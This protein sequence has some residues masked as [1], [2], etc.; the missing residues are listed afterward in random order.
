MSD[1][2]STLDDADDPGGADSE[3]IVQSAAITEIEFLVR[4]AHRVAAL[5][6]LVER[7][8]SR[9]DL[10]ALTAASP[11]TIARML[12]E[13][14]QRHWIE[15]DGH[16]YRATQLGVFVAS[17]L[18]E[19]L[20]RIET[21]QQLRDVWHSLPSE[22]CGFTLE[23]VADAVVTVAETDDPYCPVN[24]FVS[25]LKETNRFRF[26]GVNMA[27][28]EPCKDE[29][30][31]RIVNGMQTEIINLPS[32]ARY[33]LSTY[34]EHCSEPIETGNLTVQ[35][36]TDLPVSGICLFDDCIAISAYNHDSGT[37]QA[38]IDTDAP[39]ARQWAESTYA[40]YRRE[41]RP[42]VPGPTVPH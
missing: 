31:Q 38:L 20:D 14:E 33:V 1:M 27:L 26:A 11:S 13:F 23:T 35:T 6:A 21:E 17:G 39:E 32:V 7:P 3:R 22:E 12:C 18:A 41:A 5:D 2:N 4:S 40:S 10:L 36:H 16:R 25:L 15:R 30:R 42:F 8:Q 28:V 24:R 9:A 29:F 19:L 34:P 37:V